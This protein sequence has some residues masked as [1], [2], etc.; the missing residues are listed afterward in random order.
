MT[1]SVKKEKLLTYSFPSLVDTQ[2][3]PSR[4]GLLG[5]FCSYRKI[6]MS[7]QEI[8]KARADAVAAAKAAGAIPGSKDISALDA[9]PPPLN[10]ATGLFNSADIATSTVNNAGKAPPMERIFDEVKAKDA[11]Q[12]FEDI[13]QKQII[14]SRGEKIKS[15]GGYFYAK[16]EE[17]INL[18][19]HFVEIGKVSPMAS[20]SME[21]KK[22]SKK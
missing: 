4:D 15:V 7:M 9:T 8:L 20:N 22:E 18:L 10:Q 2:A 5:S 17:E 1:L 14:N 6:Q 16:T 11:L 21:E 13:T 3:T 12:V 19:N